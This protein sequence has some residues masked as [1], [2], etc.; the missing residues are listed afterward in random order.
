ME[1]RLVA[2][3]EP[4]GKYDPKAPLEGNEDNMFVNPDLADRSPVSIQS[5]VVL[6]LGDFGCLM[7]VADG[8]G[9]MNAG[10]VA[11]AIAIETV[12]SL[13]AADK[14]SSELASSAK[15]RKRYLEFVIKEADKEIK[16]TARQ[17]PDK[18][19][20]GSTIILAWLAA[21]GLTVSWC[22][23]SRAYL[24]NNGDGLRP[25]SEDHSY[26]QELVKAHKLEYV[27]TFDHPQG[28]IITRSL[29]DP[30]KGAEP[31]TREFAVEEG[32][33][34]LLC[35]DGLSGV[36]RDRKTKD[37]DGNYYPGDN[38]EDIIR[39]NQDS[40]IQCRKALFEAAEKAEWYDNVT[41]VLCQIISGGTMHHTQEDRNKSIALSPRVI[42]GTILLFILLIVCTA[43]LSYRS[44]GIQA[45]ENIDSLSIIVTTQDSLLNEKDCVIGIQ[46][47]IIR[48][49]NEAVSEQVEKKD[50][51]R[52]TTQT[53]PKP[54]TPEIVVSSNDSQGDSDTKNELYPVS[55]P[56]TLSN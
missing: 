7:V 52:H 6:P 50:N 5:D 12:K 47:S 29:G 1:I 32:D 54:Q 11:S 31:E 37:R 43:I 51:K 26:V 35:S 45:K 30:S 46:D 15:G 22:G 8:M 36:L 16:K 27:D 19:G 18:E 21:D 20:M 9:G 4:A 33:I 56:D 2:W 17:D 44:G 41:V 34:I 40:L 38:I 3:S 28:N 42:L 13:F 39:N 49:F 53:Q 48:S 55:Q 25:L 24:F 14:I 10:E 23:D